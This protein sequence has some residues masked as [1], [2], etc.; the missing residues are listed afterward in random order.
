MSGSIAIATHERGWHSERLQR[1][2]AAGG[3]PARTV[4][5]ADCRLCLPHPGG[6]GLHIPGFADALP[7]G[8]LVRGV[9][10]GTLEEIVLYLDVLHA[11][12]ELGVPVHNSGKGIERA[13]DKGM[14]SF[15]LHRAG[16]PTP[17]AWVLREPDGARQIAE[18]ERR[19]GH[20]L[21][22]K[23]LFGAQGKGII[24]VAGSQDIPAPE[25]YQNVYYLQRY[26]APAG[27]RWHDWRVF[28]VA[29]RTVA[30]MRRE[31]KTWINNVAT[32]AA[33]CPAV[34]DATMCRIAEDAVRALGL[35]YAGVDVIRDA[36]DRLS[37][38]EVNS[39]PAWKGLQSVSDVDI[40]ERVSG[41]LIASIASQKELAAV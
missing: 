18:R 41:R 6:T 26:V 32:G 30:A 22:L 35:D 2:F 5:L 20:A 16:V 3:Y 25:D 24:R 19:A 28:V 8:V 27:S 7:L 15:L 4:S 23:P 31:G 36:H 37:V 33:C 34:P 1:A 29:G 11:L 17:P 39:V 12:H 10:G 21:V 14:T 38:V 13:V 9:P 40:A